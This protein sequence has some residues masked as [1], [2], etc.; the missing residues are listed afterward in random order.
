MTTAL[1]ASI[2]LIDHSGSALSYQ[3]TPLRRKQGLLSSATSGEEA[4][5]RIREERP[6]LVI[7]PFDLFDM[8]APDLC[9]EIRGDPDV[10]QTS[11]LF[12][13][14]PDS[15]R[16]IDLCMAAGCNE[17]ILRPFT[18][19]E[20][21][22]KIASLTAIPVRRELRILTRIDISVEKNGVFVLGHSLNICLT[23]MLVET[24]H[25]FPLHSVIR[26]HF[27]IPGDPSP[28]Q[29]EARIMRSEFTGLHRYGVHFREVSSA[30]RERL[31]FFVKRMIS[32]E[33]L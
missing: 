10:R 22:Q 3:E 2:L 19:V 32:R 13:S 9:R 16:E 7:F 27:Y 25:L 18:S 21:E 5:K 26:A 29:L 6:S 1:T 12:I 11:L 23:G 30:D 15:E 17:V 4:L 20:L 14:D 28:L 33:F 8:T 24:D 31:E